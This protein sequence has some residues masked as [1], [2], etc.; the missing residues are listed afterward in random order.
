MRWAASALSSTVSKLKN[1]APKLRVCVMS[2]PKSKA[3]TSPASA[4][5]LPNPPG[6]GPTS[7]A[8]VAKPLADV[9]QR[10]KQLARAVPYDLHT[11]ANQE[12]RSELHDNVRSRRPQ[13]ERQA[14]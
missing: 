3:K 7:A 10:A 13:G 11:Y 9:W 6:D 2:W 12:K 14:I 4:F 1:I 8:L 5:P